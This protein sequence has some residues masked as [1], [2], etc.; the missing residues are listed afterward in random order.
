MM[1]LNNPLERV[2]DVIQSG[3]G[4]P[5]VSEEGRTFLF[6]NVDQLDPNP[7]QPRQNIE[8]AALN[9]LQNSI[10]EV[11]I[12]EPIL[13]RQKEDRYQI[14]S[15]ERRWRACQALE[16]EELP[17]ILKNV[18]DEESFKL[19][20][21]ENVQRNDLTPLEEAVAYKKL[22]DMDIAKNQAEIGKMIG[23]RQQRVSDKLRLLELP[24]E[25]QS[26]FGDNQNRFTQKHGEILAR[27]KDGKKIQEAAQKV[28]EEHLS[29]RETL[30]L[31]E[32]RLA[33]RRAKTTRD[34][35]PRRRLHLAK[36]RHGFTLKLTFDSRKDAIE[37]S[38]QELERM[39]E[40]LRI[41]FG[42]EPAR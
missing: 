27:L 34:M 14:I 35:Q 30:K 1:K 2:R 32:Q 10:A 12:I 33:I 6:L 16:M 9:E 22:L 38:L 23:I 4:E 5:V 18:S 15:G 7:F 24:E 39:V 11:G 29:T 37:D 42:K 40:K 17:C 13:V 8:G 21:T 36:S 25:V 41:E 31:V 26:F 28:I 20:L 19:A 3:M